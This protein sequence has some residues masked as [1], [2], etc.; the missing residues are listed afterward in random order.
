M[1]ISLDKIN[2]ALDRLDSKGGSN[3]NQDNIVKLDEGEHQIRIAPYKEDLDM[4]FQELWFHFRIG[5]RTFLCPNKMKNEPDPICDF[6]STCWNEFTKTKDETYKEMFKTM[7]PT[8]RVYLPVMVRGEEDKGLRWWS[9]SP[10]TTYKEILNHVRSGLRQNVDITDTSEGLDLMVTVAPGFNNWLMP[11]SITTALKGTPLAPKN[12][13]KEV[14]DTI[15]PLNQL[16]DYSPVDEMKTALE[17]HLNPNAND[18][19]SSSGT[20]LNF[21]ENSDKEKVSAEEDTTNTKIDDAFDKL[22]S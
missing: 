8:L 1:A 6:A 5:G 11:T 4:P 18:S 21:G 12:K 14:I 3:Q 15:E 17:K 19:D 20:L 9:I 13:V 10:R 16:F 2:S 7:A 22:L